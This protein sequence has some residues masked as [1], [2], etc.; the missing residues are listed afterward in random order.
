MKIHGPLQQ[1]LRQ[2][3]PLKVEAQQMVLKL[4]IKYSM[5]MET[6]LCT[7]AVVVDPAGGVVPPITMGDFIEF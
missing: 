4:S 3:Q 7:T 6:M 2:E 5:K 1:T